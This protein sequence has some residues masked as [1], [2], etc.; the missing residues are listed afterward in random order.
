MDF[1]PGAFQRGGLRPSSVAYESGLTVAYESGLQ[2]F[3]ATPE[4]YD[5]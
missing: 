2:M 1:A 3:A 5:R 4:P